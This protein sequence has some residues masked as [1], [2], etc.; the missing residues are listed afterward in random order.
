MESLHHYLILER[1]DRDFLLEAIYHVVKK[2]QGLISILPP[3]S[4]SRDERTGLDIDEEEEEQQ[5][6]GNK[7]KLNTEEDEWGEN[8]VAQQII[9]ANKRPSIKRSRELDVF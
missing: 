9:A 8:S 2:K 7:E 4:S 5:Q 1:K 6:T 3:M